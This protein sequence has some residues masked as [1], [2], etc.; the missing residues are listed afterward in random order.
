MKRKRYKKVRLIRT[1]FSI[2]GEHAREIGKRVRRSR[3]ESSRSSIVRKALD[4][5]LLNRS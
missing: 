2:R 3:G 1:S 4:Y 5:Y